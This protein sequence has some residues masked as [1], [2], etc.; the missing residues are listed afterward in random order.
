LSTYKK[1]LEWL[2]SQ[3]PMYQRAGKI[4][5]KA[6]LK[7]SISLDRHLS[8]PHTFYK[9]IHIAGT[10]G[11]GST[12]HMVASVLQEAGYKVGLYTS[13]HLKDFR[14][15]I[16][17]NGEMCSEQFVVDFVD[18]NK[19]FFKEHQLSFFEMTVGMAFQYFKEQKVDVAVIETGLGGRLDSTN[20]ITPVV[21]A[22]TN[23]DK[24]H[25]AILGNTYLKIAAEKAGIIKKYIPVVI[26]EKRNHLKKLFKEKATSLNSPVYFIDHRTT[27]QPT[28][29]KGD[30]QSSNVKVAEKVIELLRKEDFTI[31]S[32]ALKSGLLN[33]V[34]NTNLRGRYEVVSESPKTILDTAHNV[35]GIRLLMHQ[36]KAEK[37]KELHIVLGMVSDKD[38]TSVLK[39]FP[40]TAFYYISKPDIPRGME[41]EVLG[42]HL[43][44]FHLNFESFD[45]INQAFKTAQ[46]RALKG[47]V[48]LATGSTFVVA[49]II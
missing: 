6:D 27:H 30:Y 42:D 23:I 21:T 2:F 13:P 44:S 17:I 3:L 20:I 33:V 48:I 16:R 25:T 26:G 32:A 34:R 15:R 35:A 37:C 24:D 29:L 22:I 5:Y 45:T 19:S 28:D 46:K 49:E 9:T 36:I 39:L 41:I 31:S 1:T 43:N 14:E 11:K 10:N 47:D 4:A 40:K 12:S 8:H 7:N 18:H 38:V